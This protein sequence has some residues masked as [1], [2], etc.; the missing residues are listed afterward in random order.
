MIASR[1]LFS[2]LTLG[3]IS[4]AAIPAVVIIEKRE[5]VSDILT[6]NVLVASKI[7][8]EGNIS[9][10]LPHLSDAL[11]TASTSF[12]GFQA[13]V[14]TNTGRWKQ[15]VANAVAPVYN[16]HIKLYNLGKSI[17]GGR[18]LF[19]YTI[20]AYFRIHVLTLQLR[21]NRDRKK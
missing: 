6:V 7:A 13:K 9:P 12:T 5:D 17:K 8:T 21:R 11:G 20:L 3:V 18:G 15:D 14:D 19:S 2:F 16:T 1:I 4:A 10:L